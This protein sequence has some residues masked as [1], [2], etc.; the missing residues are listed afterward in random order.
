VRN[1]GVLK[2]GMAKIIDIRSR[3]EKWPDTRIA[4]TPLEFRR[5]GWELSSFIQMLRSDS[6]EF[7]RKR[8]HMPG[9]WRTEPGQL[10]PH[11]SLRN[12]TASTLRAL[13]LYR[14]REE[15]MREVYFLAGL[16]DCMI[17][18]I[19]PILRTALVRDMYKKIFLMKKDLGVA[20]HG[21]LKRVLLPV[22]PLLF[23]QQEY[24]GALRASGSLKELYD[25]IR[26]GTGEL[27]DLLSSKYVFY[28]PG[29]M[30]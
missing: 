12:G 18:Q 27:F 8:R 17:N 5:A 4:S 11:F 21:P 26:K 15:R 25:V 10:P 16:I 22:D 7:E 9:A 23:S 1:P 19:N 24:Q 28:L 2:K 13:F 6:E 30:R 14:D 29:T 20:W 3:S